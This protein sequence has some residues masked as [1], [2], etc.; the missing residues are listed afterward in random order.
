MFRVLREF[1]MS[2]HLRWSKAPLISIKIPAKY[3]DED[4]STFWVSRLIASV[5]DLP[6]AN[7]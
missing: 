5:M 3:L 4:W 2:G 6:L 1:S 7:P